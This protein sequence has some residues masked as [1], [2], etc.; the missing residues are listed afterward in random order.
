MSKHPISKHKNIATAKRYSSEGQD[1]ISN[2][3]Q[4]RLLTEFRE[5]E[6][7]GSRVAR[8]WEDVGS[9]WSGVR[10]QLYEIYDELKRHNS[11]NGKKITLLLLLNW[12][13]FF[14]NM[15][16]ARQW[17]GKFEEIGV[18]VNT[19]ERWI[20]HEN[21]EEQVMLAFEL[22]QA[23]KQSDQLSSNIKN[24]QKERLARKVYCHNMPRRFYRRNYYEQRRYTIEPIE[25]AF[26]ASKA[27]CRQIL[28]Q[29]VPYS[30]AH[31][32]N[33]GEEVLGPLTTWR[34][35][36]EKP[37][38]ACLYRGEKMNM[39]EMVTVEEHHMLV[40]LFDQNKMRPD[41]RKTNYD[42]YPAHGVLRCAKCL[43]LTTTSR[44]KSY[45][46]T[47]IEYHVC[48]HA[49]PRHYRVQA[50]KV[51]VAAYEMVEELTLN[52]KTTAAVIEE[53]KKIAKKD[54]AKATTNLKRLEKELK[55]IKE[56]YENATLKNAMGSFTDDQLKMVERHYHKKIAEV[57]EARTVVTHYAE[58]LT[59]ALVSINDIGAMIRGT[60]EP[61][62]FNDFLKMTFPDGLVFDKESG[63]F[64]TSSMNAAFTRTG[65][66]SGS[67]HRIKI[68]DAL[69]SSTPPVVWRQTLPVRTIASDLKLV[70]AYTNKYKTA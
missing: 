34:Q 31:E 42:L 3:I 47:Y 16:R 60:L 12:K 10:G 62:Q 59:Q 36:I 22:Y 33:G 68:G 2:E 48:H 11:R 20:D 1:P 43:G 32:I 14:R 21:P 70:H 52:A 25:P 63:I 28:Y 27:A 39:P 57:E 26:S 55:G 23:Q 19:V 9:A 41:V 44:P 64:R 58:I 50:G 18:E 15:K 8:T 54:K 53:T 45:N 40:A 6:A 35:M 5:K 67:Y 69:L 61:Q 66:Q 4:D 24:G 38:A 49:N 30:R 7:P 17:I 51:N 13:R 46:G 65:W 29:G 37:L 56:G